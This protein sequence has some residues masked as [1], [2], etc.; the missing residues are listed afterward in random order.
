MENK[1]CEIV[2][3]LIPLYIDNISSDDSSELIERHCKECPEC[4]NYLNSAK[5]EIKT[6]SQNEETAKKIT[7]SL[8][9]Q[10][11]SKIIKRAFIASFLI[12]CTFIFGFVC[13]IVYSNL[14]PNCYEEY[15]GKEIYS[16]LNEGS[17]PSDKQEVQPIIKKVDKALKFTGNEKSA[18]K[19]FGELAWYTPAYASEIEGVKVV[20][21]KVTFLTAK[22]YHDTGYLWI[23]YSQY[24]YEKN[25]DLSF[26]SADIQ[27]RI[28][29]V[30][31]GDEWTAVNV[32]EAP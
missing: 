15:F 7:Q 8:N 30:K 24:G 23:K 3:D 1:K 32:M 10:R 29:L 12:V 16:E 18:K 28:T 11:K 6:N 13:N 27:S 20:E 5:E 2:R 25:G 4:Q 14:Q 19:R 31:Y 26:G 17:S 21:A 22:L 9:K